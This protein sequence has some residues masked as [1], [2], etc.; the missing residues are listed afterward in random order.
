[1]STLHNIYSI[2]EQYQKVESPVRRTE[3]NFDAGAKF[4]VATDSEY[5]NYFIAYILEFQLHKAMCNVAGQLDNGAPLHKCDI[6]G[7]KAV[8]ERLAAGLSVG[9][10]RH[11]S[12]TLQ[13]MTGD[14]ELKSD[15]L[16]EYFAPLMD[17]L[18]V[19]NEQWEAQTETPI[20]NAP[21]TIAPPT[22]VP[23]VPNQPDDE[24][25]AIP[26]IPIIVGAVIGGAV[27]IGVV[28]A[29]TY[30][31]CKRNSPSPSYIRSV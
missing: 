29:L 5:I 20:T 19:A 11:W 31:L 27:L 13:Q 24:E 18:R 2:S 12:E 16:L 17:Y 14:T 15:A 21:I 26:W 8:G 22:P 3:A 30:Y 6:D 1:M 10:S 28:V 25:E 7:S 9:S 23:D 4:H